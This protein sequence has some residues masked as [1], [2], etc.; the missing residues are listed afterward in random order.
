MNK[1]K[2]RVVYGIKNIIYIRGRN[3]FCGLRM[4][5]TFGWWGGRRGGAG[6]S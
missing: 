5:V 1:I 4:I 2:L 3:F 6:R